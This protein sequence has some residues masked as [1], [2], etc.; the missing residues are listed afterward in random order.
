MYKDVEKLVVFAIQK[1]GYVVQKYHTSS[2]D[3]IQMVYLH[4]LKYPP[5]K[6]KLS[7]AVIKTVNQIFHSMKDTEKEKRAAIKSFNMRIDA[8]LDKLR[9]YEEY[10]ELDF[11]CLSRLEKKIIELYFG[12]NNKTRKTSRQI[13][14]I[15]KIG[16]TKVLKIKTSA[17]QKLKEKV[18]NE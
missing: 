13:G 2:D 14:R 4:L 18:K 10:S 7:T 5:K 3:I 9:L 11:S 8:N 16:R 17:I 12:L 1:H 15:L 6:C